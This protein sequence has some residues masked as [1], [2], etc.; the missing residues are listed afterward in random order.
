MSTEI[1]AVTFVSDVRLGGSAFGGAIRI[2]A[3]HREGVAILVL[4]PYRRTGGTVEYGDLS[5][6]AG[7]RRVWTGND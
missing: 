6:H 5:A 4:L 2:E 3:D 1:R 7:E